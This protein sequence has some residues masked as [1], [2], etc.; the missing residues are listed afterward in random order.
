M[1]E[2]S[3]EQVH[4]LSDFVGLSLCEF[5]FDFIRK[6][7]LEMDVTRYG[8]HTFLY[9]QFQIV[10]EKLCFIEYS[11]LVWRIVFDFD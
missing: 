6:I 2:G 5:V 1:S 7:D 3:P 4:N 10:I 9:F 8:I 11:R